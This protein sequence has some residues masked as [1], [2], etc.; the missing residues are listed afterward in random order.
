MN[1]KKVKFLLINPT[2]PLWRVKANQRPVNSGVFRF[3]MLPS[4]YVAASMPDYVETKIVDE[5]VEPVDFNTDADLIGISFMTFNAPRAYEIADIFRS[6]GKTVIFGGYHPTFMSEEAIQHAD[7]ICLGEAENNVPRMM[8]DFMA[9]NLKPFYQNELVDLE[10]LPAVDRNLLKN[11]AY[12][13]LNAMQATRGCYHHCEFCSVAAFNRYKI[14]KR[15]IEKVLEELKGLGRYVLFMDDNIILDKAY[16]KALFKAMIPY[17][18]RW[19]SQCGMDITDD[20]ELLDLAARSGCG[21]LFIGFES[22]SQDSLSDWKKHCNRKRNYLEVVKKIH[23]AGIGIFAGFVFGGDNEG[24]DVFRNTL[25]FL[26]EANIEVLQATR[27]TPFPGTP[28]FEKMKKGKR[29]FDTDWSHYDFFHVVFQPN[30]MN[31]EELHTGTAWLQ[32]QFYSNKNIIR[33]ILKATHYY[34]PELIMRVVAPMNFG[35]R[36]KLKAYN[37]FQLGTSFSYG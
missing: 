5:D 19:F 12:L 36:H 31:P 4:L 26:L 14:R 30:N 33:R 17:N 28:L 1:P 18:K 2:S 11:N 27:L 9:G 15:P 32:K 16:A 24:P 7:S 37:A 20:D 3:S 21:G 8:E 6:K 25:D 10:N 23:Q 29:I 13:T 34:K 35:Y 22:L